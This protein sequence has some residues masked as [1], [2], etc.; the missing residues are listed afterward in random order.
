[1]VIGIDEL[2]EEYVCKIFILQHLLGH[3]FF[4]SQEALLTNNAIP[5]NVDTVDSTSLRSSNRSP[6]SSVNETFWVPAINPRHPSTHS[7][8]IATTSTG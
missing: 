8:A 5:Y 3:C 6:V 7:D 2:K 4:C 1:M